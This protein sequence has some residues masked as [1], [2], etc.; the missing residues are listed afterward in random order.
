MRELVTRFSPQVDRA[1]SDP[2]PLPWLARLGGSQAAWAHTEWGEV[3]KIA[4][5]RPV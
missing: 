4:W 2:G 3:W 5:Y 1:A